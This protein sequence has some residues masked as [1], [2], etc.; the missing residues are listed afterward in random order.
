MSPAP[1]HLIIAIPTYNTGAKV[2]P[3]VRE[4]LLTGAPVIVIIDGS[5]DGTAELLA[6][7]TPEFANLE[8][9]QHPQNRGKGAA[10]LT[11]ARRAEERGATHLLTFDADGQHPATSLAEFLQTSA[12]QPAAMVAGCPSFPTDAPWE[13]VFF[14]KWANWWTN[15]LSVR[16]G[17]GDSMFG[18]RIYPLR[19]LREILEAG[20]MGQ[21]YDLECVAAIKLGWQGVP[22]VNLATPVVYFKAGEGGVSHYRY[23]YDNVRLGLVYLVL[24]PQAVW[25]HVLRRC[26]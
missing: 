4:V 10:I 13:R 18:L 11:A 2:R 21:R 16:G 25:L 15:F 5:D 22:V 9:L 23:V 7:L 3:V 6:T 1:Y 8:I 12:D 14:R 17:L 19:P 20:E 24:I 26:Q